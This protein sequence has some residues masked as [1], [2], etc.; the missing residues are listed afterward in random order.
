MREDSLGF[1]DSVW[2]WEFQV[3]GQEL[4]DVVTFDIRSFFQFND[5]QDVDRSKSGSV[6]GSQIFVQT[7]NSTGSG[8]ISV[9]FVHIVGTRSGVVSDPDTKVLDV[10]W[11]SFLDDVNRN[12]FT[13]SLLD[14]VQLLQE[15]PVSRL[16]NHSV[17][18]KDSHTVQ[19]W[20]WNVFSWQTTTN[21]FVFTETRH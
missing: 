18:S 17:W 7:F 14:F 5:L 10:S 21:N 13:R 20:F 11:V 2:Q 15:V 6:S 12:N 19:L 9:F 16:C 4:F 3:L 1:L 8:N